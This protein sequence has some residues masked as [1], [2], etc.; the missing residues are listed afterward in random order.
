MKTDRDRRY[1][2]EG[3]VRYHDERIWQQTKK[4]VEK[5]KADAGKRDEDSRKFWSQVI[6]ERVNIAKNE[7]LQSQKKTAAIALIATA[8]TVA[9]L[10]A[11]IL[12]VD[13]P[14]R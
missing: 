2:L 6:M 9:N 4:L 14:P 10:G 7:I 13:K 12:H 8:L 3:Y 5:E 11:L 1:A